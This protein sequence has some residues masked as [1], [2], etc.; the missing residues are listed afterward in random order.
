M[1]V[2]ATAANFL[3]APSLP[4]S[5]SLLKGARSLILTQQLLGEVTTMFVYQYLRLEGLEVETAQ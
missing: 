3:K 4:P 5:T 2:P 1:D